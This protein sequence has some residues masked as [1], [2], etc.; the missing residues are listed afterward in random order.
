MKTYLRPA[1]GLAMW[2]LA[3]M[4]YAQRMPTMAE[5]Y[6]DD[7]ARV[8]TPIV[9]IAGEGDE[10]H[11]RLLQLI[12]RN[13][14]NADQ[15]RAQL[16]RALMRS[17]R[18]ETGRAM[19]AQL[20][21]TLPA[22]APMRSAVH[23]NYGWDLYRAGKP[24]DALAQWVLATE[25]RLLKPSWVPPTLALGLWRADRRDE[26]VQWYAAAVRTEPQA[27]ND[28]ARFPQLLPDWTDAERATLTEVFT[29][30]RA[31][32]PTWP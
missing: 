9:A 21:D 4:A 16:A 12:D 24:D 19:Y 30:W 11:G 1:L 23:W 29:A 25:G 15:A 32:P 17:G 18:E 20:L 5:F 6:F 22:R 10:V 2:L 31:N 28:P 3:S 8:A 14:R 7:D 26:A 13:A 27:W